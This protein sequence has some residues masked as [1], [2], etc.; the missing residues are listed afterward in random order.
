MGPI[1]PGQV[2]TGFAA[3]PPLGTAASRPAALKRSVRD[4]A[5]TGV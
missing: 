1:V 4:V 3:E 5:L 2:G